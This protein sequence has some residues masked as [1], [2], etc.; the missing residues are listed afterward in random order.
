[1]TARPSP[2]RR[3]GEGRKR[4]IK[5]ER[6]N[7]QTLQALDYRGY[8]LRP[9]PERVLQFGEGGFKRL[10]NEGFSCERAASCGLSRITLL[11]S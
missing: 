9:A 1:M 8:L 10:M 5:L 4:G 2:V 6:L 7:Y 3:A 11:T